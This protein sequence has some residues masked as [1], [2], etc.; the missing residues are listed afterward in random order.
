MDDERVVRVA[1]VHGMDAEEC[2]DGR[3]TAEELVSGELPASVHSPSLGRQVE[4]GNV[5]AGLAVARSKDVAGRGPL[6]NPIAAIVARP[7][8]VGSH[9]RPVEVHVDGH[10]GGGGGVGQSPLELHDLGQA[11][12]RAAERLG[13]GHVQVARVPQ[14]GPVLVE[15]TVVAVVA[16]GPLVE[17]GQHLFGQH[18]VHLHPGQ[19]R[20]HVC[21]PPCWCRGT[22][23]S[24]S[25][26]VR[27]GGCGTDA[28]VGARKPV[29]NRLA[30]NGRQ[31]RAATIDLRPRPRP[32]AP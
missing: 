16:G 30:A 8:E 15:E 1:A 23:P 18:L 24:V 5:V 14:F 3:E 31:T 10:R 6:E 9:A 4:Q 11:Q 27:K 32:G 21:P 17:A 29:A 2:P 12:P 25:G 22:S 20:R 19:C 13:D 7:V 26:T 28:I